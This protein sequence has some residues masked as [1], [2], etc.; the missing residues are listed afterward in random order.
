MLS[1][2][3]SPEIVANH[4]GSRLR[5]SWRTTLRKTADRRVIFN[6]VSAFLHRAGLYAGVR[7]V[8][9][10]WPTRCFLIPPFILTFLVSPALSGVA[11]PQE[12]VQPTFADL[13]KSA[14]AAREAGKIEDAVR[15]YQRAVEIRAD[16]EEGWWYLGTLQYDADHFVEA[17]PALE[18][19]VQL[20]PGNGPAWNFLGLCE[21]ETHDYEKSLHHL[22]KGQELGTGDDPEIS[23]VSRYHLALLLNRDAEFERASAMLALAFGDQAPAQ[24][25]VALGLALLR[26]PLLPQ[27][28]DPSQ[29]AL[30]QAAGETASLLARGDSARTLDSFRALLAKYPNAPYL[31]Y[32]FGTALASAARDDEALLQQQEELKISP[33]SA[34]LRI[35]ISSLELRSHNPRGALRA[36]EMAVQLASNSP[37]A[38]R[39]LAQSLQALGQKE[40]AAAEL[41]VSKS[42]APE[43]GVRDTRIIQMYALQPA[44][45]V[46]EAAPA[47]ANPAK[48]LSFDELSRQAAASLA[49]GHTDEAIHI[50]QEALQL[51]PEWDEGRWNLAMLAYSARHYPEAIV[52]LKACVARRP[53]YGTAWAVLGLSEFEIKDFSNALIHLQRGQDLGM[54]GSKESVQLARYRLGVLLNRNAEFDRTAELLAPEAGPGPLAEKIQFALGMSLLRISVL[55]DEVESSKSS[56]V[57]SAGEIAALLQDSKYDAVFPKFQALLQQYPAV[58]FL[59]YAY[60]TALEALSQYDD[61]ESQLRQEILISPKSELPYVRMASIALK[62]RRPADA[63]PSAQRAVQLAPDSA[64]AHYLLGRSCLEVGQREKALQELETASKMAPGSPEV[65]FNLAKAYTK[66]NLPEKAEQERAT[67]ARLNALA[68][69]Q[70]SRH[71][72]QSYSGS[73]DKT[74]FSIPRAEPTGVPESH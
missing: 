36:A 62:T 66:A 72:N 27:E 52:A 70:R 16:W 68:E 47:A 41:R 50:Y 59:H 11:R 37:A 69:L 74:D 3:V 53:D 15:D 45:V 55:P 71:G 21:F 26:A 32:A 1:F 40:K 33:Q 14:T 25:K 58:P 13:E 65:H 20:D 51:H 42:L 19:V 63:L 46:P 28:V 44:T 67:F 23:R 6:S 56:L 60:G 57:L 10:T 17:T 12:T 64:E 35:E 39:A 48:S 29:D 4:S 73:H 24:A 43:K 18:E 61:A 54:G 5:S 2:P 49:A 34:L 8:L 31:H 22:Q 38:H 9:N 30:V 7:V